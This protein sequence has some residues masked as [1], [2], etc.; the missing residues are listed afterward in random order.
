MTHSGPRGR[1]HKNANCVATAALLL[2]AKHGATYGDMNN[3]VEGLMFCFC[4][5]YEEVEEARFNCATSA[6]IDLK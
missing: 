3:P 4:L 6:F 1:R 2:H 5:L